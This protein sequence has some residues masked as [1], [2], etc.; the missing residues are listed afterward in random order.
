MGRKVERSDPNLP[1]KKG[2]LFVTISESQNQEGGGKGDIENERESLRF[3][4]E[5]VQPSQS[6]FNNTAVTRIQRSLY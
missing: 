3:E 6:Q 2:K 1:F 5:M 4:S